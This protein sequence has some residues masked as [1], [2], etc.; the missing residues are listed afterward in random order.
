MKQ[1]QVDATLPAKKAADGSFEKG[2]E[3]DKAGSIFVNYAESL[4]EALEMFGEEAVLSNAFANWRVT[5]QA[6]IRR[7]LAAGKTPDQMQKEF[8]TAKMGVA[9]S[10][11]KVDPIQASLAKF[12]GMTADEQAAYIQ[13]LRELATE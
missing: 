9:T 11:G 5:L 12:K 10:G 2:R 4:D 7:G 13:Q 8:A 6:G 1:V 3:V